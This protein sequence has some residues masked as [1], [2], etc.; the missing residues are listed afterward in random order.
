MEAAWSRECS[1]PTA[2]EEAPG[3]SGVVV[4]AAAGEELVRP[5][6]GQGDGLT[7]TGDAAVIVDTRTAKSSN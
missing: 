3:E 6:I 5:T 2:G 4:A 1:D 7:P